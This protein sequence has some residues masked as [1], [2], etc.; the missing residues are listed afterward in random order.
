MFC[1]LLSAGYVSSAVTGGVSGFFK[2]AS[3][4]GAVSYIRS[5]ED[6]IIIQLQIHSHNQNDLENDRIIRPILTSVQT[7][8]QFEKLKVSQSDIQSISHSDSLS[9]SLYD[10]C[11]MV[12]W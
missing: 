10:S 9:V 8:F 3:K 1:C 11:F 5:H 2:S 4:Y 7:E 6:F 12:L